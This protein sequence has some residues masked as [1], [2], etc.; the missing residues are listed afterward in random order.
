MTTSPEARLTPEE[1]LRIERAAEWRSEYVDGAVFAMAGASLRH[2]LIVGNLVRELGTQLRKGPCLV[3]AVDLR[4]ATD[5]RRHYTYPD[6]VVVCDP[7]QFVDEHQD[8]VTNPVFIAEVLSDSTERYDR[9]AKF[10]RY[11]GVPTILEYL[12]ISQERVH[13]ELYTRQADG[14]WFLRE[15]NDPGSEIDIASLRCSLRVAE[16]YAKVEPGALT[17]P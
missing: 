10:E 2:T 9:G 5:R 16:V 4:V 11:R 17:N 12:L 7:P 14:V 8:T 1:Y 13:V 6:V 15:W 3:S